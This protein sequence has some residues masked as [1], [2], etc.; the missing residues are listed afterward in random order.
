MLEGKKPSDIP[1]KFA[2]IPSELDFLVDL[3]AAKNCG[4]TIPQKYIDQ[5]NLIFQNGVL[6][7]K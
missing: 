3:D 4:I 1:V 5:A 2:T 6:T 7:E